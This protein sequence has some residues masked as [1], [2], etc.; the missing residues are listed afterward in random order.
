CNLAVILVD[1]RK[2]VLAQTRRHSF[3][4]S[5]LGI[6]HLVVAVNKMDLVDWSQQRFEEIR[7]D[8]SDFAAKLEVTD[9]EF[10]PMSALRG[11]NVVTRSELM[12]WYE[13]RPM[14]DYLENVHIASDV[15]LI[16]LRLPVQYVLRPDLDFRG[17]SGTV[18]S[19]ILR[20]GDEI[21]VF[22]SGRRVRVRSIFSPDGERE[23]AFAPLSVTVVLDEEVDVSRGDVFAHPN[24]AP[25]IG[26][27][28]E[29]MVVWMH[30]TPLRPDTE[31]LLKQTTV[32]TA[33][34]VTEVRY[35]MNVNTIH[36]EPAD[37][38]GLNEIGRLRIETARPLVHDPYEKNRLTGAF[39]LIDRVTN[40]TLGAGM[41]LDR[42][43]ADAT[44]PARAAF[45]STVADDARW[46]RAGQRPLLIRIEGDAAGL[47]EA[48]AALEQALFDRG[49]L[50]VA[51]TD[52]SGARLALTLGA[53]VVAPA[54]VSGDDSGIAAVHLQLIDD[55]WQL[56]EGEPGL[57][58]E[59]VVEALESRGSL[60]RVEGPSR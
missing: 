58:T 29:A 13:G 8:F 14:L 54:S 12:P 28:F 41:I 18:A 59:Q 1:A 20:R 47:D 4:A 40:A 24:N 57:T 52:P 34:R 56:D 50:T 27:D 53:V 23:E 55:R 49:W 15:N 10:I 16:D 19:G 25:T 60:Q 22:P 2:G 43:A 51:A 38:L 17:Y 42:E 9:I 31:Y 37:A 39:I 5:L 7:A 46:A 32:Q 11:D 3:I 48:A 26:R 45:R 44:A 30:E 6:K 35:R 21:A 36:R 33:A